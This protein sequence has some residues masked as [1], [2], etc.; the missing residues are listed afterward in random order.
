METGS[1][2][3]PDPMQR[4]AAIKT[5]NQ[6]AGWQRMTFFPLSS[7]WAE[8]DLQIVCGSATEQRMVCTSIG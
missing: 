2:E 1:I 7:L 5:R 4:S 3:G 8:A 6:T